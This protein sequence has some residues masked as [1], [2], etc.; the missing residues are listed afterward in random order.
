VCLPGSG[1]IAASWSVVGGGEEQRSVLASRWG[2]GSDASAVSSLSRRVST[3]LRPVLVDLSRNRSTRLERGWCVPAAG[4]CRG[5][6]P[7]GAGPATARADTRT[8]RHPPNL[9]Q[10]VVGRSSRIRRRGWRPSCECPAAQGREGQ[11]DPGGDVVIE[12]V[13]R[14]VSPRAW[15]GWRGRSSPF[16]ASASA[17]RP[18]RPPR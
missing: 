9:L 17:G 11:G 12:Q 16:C 2:A 4:G 1:A 14:T 13:E 8:E 10:R 15:R 18:R 3:R 7:P 6:R 5:R